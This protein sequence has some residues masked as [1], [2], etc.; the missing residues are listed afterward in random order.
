MKKIILLLL[1]I[2][3]L[4]LATNAQTKRIAHRSHSGIATNYA[5]F[6]DDNLG[7]SPQM[8]RAMARRY[9]SIQAL[10]FILKDSALRKQYED[11]IAN[12]KKIKNA[13]KKEKVNQSKKEEKKTTPKREKKKQNTKPLPPNDES[14]HNN[15]PKS[16]FLL[17]F[18][19]AVPT[20]AIAFFT[21]KK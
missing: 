7:L 6:E 12:A 8:E 9:D 18:L 4:S 3:F 15:A 10:K 17:L 19:I 11:S 21:R 13:K 16:R 5:L 14:R 1:C 2:T 20:G